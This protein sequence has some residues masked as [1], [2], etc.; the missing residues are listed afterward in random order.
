MAARVWDRASWA[1]ISATLRPWRNSE[2]MLQGGHRSRRRRPSCKGNPG[3]QAASVRCHDAPTPPSAATPATALTSPPESRCT[4]HNLA[5]PL[6][7]RMQVPSLGV[8]QKIIK[9]RHVGDRQTLPNPSRNPLLRTYVR[10][11]VHAGSTRRVQPTVAVAVGH[12][13][14][15]RERRVT[16]HSPQMLG[17][18][19][20]REM[21]HIRF[22]AA[23]PPIHPHPFVNEVARPPGLAPVVKT[24]LPVRMPTAVQNPTAQILRQP[25]HGVGVDCWDPSS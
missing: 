7:I 16:V 11:N 23:E 15:G 13:L 14:R 4:T 21:Q 9:R 20:T 19:V 17:E 18:R 22:Q 2:R 10:K 5:A 12:H 24:D 1:W 25:R 3:G 8:F 6:L